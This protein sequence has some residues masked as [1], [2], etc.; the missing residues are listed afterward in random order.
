MKHHYCR[1]SKISAKH[2][3]NCVQLAY[4]LW[5]PTDRAQHPLHFCRMPTYDDRLRS[6]PIFICFISRFVDKLLLLLLL[7]LPS[8]RSLCSSHNTAHLPLGKIRNNWAGFNASKNITCYSM[9]C[10]IGPICQKQVNLAQIFGISCVC[11]GTNTLSCS[12]DLL[13]ECER[14]FVR[15]NY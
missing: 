4:L 1:L 3:Y 12:L 5:L 13:S 6:L 11:V 7:F 14:F 15:P 8:M 2:H 9:C 10:R